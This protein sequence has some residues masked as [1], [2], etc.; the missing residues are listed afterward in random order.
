MSNV[1]A[2]YRMVYALAL[3]IWYCSW[4]SN[5]FAQQHIDS[6]QNQLA[7]ESNDSVRVVMMIEL[8]REM[9]RMSQQGDEDIRMATQAMETAAALDTFLYAQALDNL[10]LLYRFYQQYQEAISFH[11]RAYDLIA[12]RDGHAVDKMRYANNAGVA[13]RY[14]ADYDMAVDYHMK[15]LR[16]AEKENNTRNIE[17]AC[18][19]I[20]N[21]LMAIPGKEKQGLEYQEKALGVAKQVGN[22]RG[23]AI[24]NLTIGGYYDQLGQHTIARTY[25]RQILA[26]NETRKDERGRGLGLKALGESYLAEGKDL[27]QAERY[28]NEALAV[29]QHV[30]DRQQQAHTLLELGNLDASRQHYKQSLPKLEEAMQIAGEL[31]DRELLHATALTISKHYEALNNYPLAL[32]YYKKAQDYQNSINLTNQAVQVSAIAGRYDVEKKESEIELL[33]SEQSVQELQLERRTSQLNARGVIIVLLIALFFVLVVVFLLR[34]K[35]RKDRIKAEQLLAKAENERLKLVYEKNLMEANILA[36]QMQINPHFLFNCLNSIKSMIQNN[37]N[38]QAT[39]YLV[40][41]ARFARIVLETANKPVHSLQDELALMVY[42]IDLEKNR[43][44][45]SFSYSITNAL[46]TAGKD[47]PLP[48]LLLQPFVE[49]AIWHGLL[50]SEKA[51]KML[52]IIV[53]QTE[54]GVQVSIDDTGVGRSHASNST[55]LHKSRGTEINNKRIALFNKSHPNSIHYEFVDK[56]DEAGHALGTAVVIRI[57]TKNARESSQEIKGVQRTL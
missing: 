46:D 12:D 16:L 37:D 18:N 45:N 24:Q 6:L 53:E 42:Y 5:V 2:G 17:I 27:Q 3:A 23:I 30:N 41:L 28:F 34:N 10:G 4:G 1:G 52:A 36:Y 35:S 56:K 43:F 26:I 22:Q 40:K 47:I 50:P 54:D 32:R 33:K 55:K 44:D 8:S 21:T 25:L 19:G 11:A 39:K 38:K 7:I 57:E 29:F 14:N 15:A 48:S 51:I 49:N 13:C 20:G 31:N 9:N